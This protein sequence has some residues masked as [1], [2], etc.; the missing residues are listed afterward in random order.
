MRQDPEIYFITI[1]GIILG[2]LL[3]GFI[4][5]MLFLYKRRQQRQEQ[6]MDKIKDMYEREA[7]RS[8][9]EIQENTFKNI[10][11]EL[12][13]NIGQMLSVVKLSLSALP[14]EPGHPS[15]V[16]INH[17]RQVLNKAIIDLSDLTKS[18]HTDRITDVGLAD[19]IE[20]ELATVKN[21]GLLQVR[22]SVEGTERQLPEQKAI[23]L[24]RMFQEILN[25]ILK[26]A[27]A[28]QVKVS[29]TYATDDTFVMKVED[30]GTGFNVV[31]KR[32]AVSSSQGV[33]L[34]SIFNRAMLIGAE[35]RIDSAPGK[36]T[37]VVVELKPSRE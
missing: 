12:H 3:V 22:F 36:G 11:Q 4:V 32:Q 18:L 6:E 28:T 26:H 29:L 37:Q 7:L 1:I 10:S 35:L 19:T 24:F 31:E 13:D 34:K 5:T 33:G 25:N 2:L 27:R 14:I 23:F 16:L 17:S 30:N 9:L 21:A 20:F 15:H 8:Q